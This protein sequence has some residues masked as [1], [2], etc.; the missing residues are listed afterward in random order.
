M[1]TGQKCEVGT[2]EKGFGLMYHVKFDA[3]A[4][5]RDGNFDEERP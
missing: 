2:H 4:S 5:K 3:F 1:I